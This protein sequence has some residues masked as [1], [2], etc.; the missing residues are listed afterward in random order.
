MNDRDDTFWPSLITFTNDSVDWNDILRLS[1]KE[2]PSSRPTS[3]IL[4]LVSSL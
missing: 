4:V 3:H 1:T 2:A